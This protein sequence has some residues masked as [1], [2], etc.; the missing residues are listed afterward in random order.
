MQGV[1]GLFVLAVIAVLIAYWVLPPF[2][3]WGVQ[4]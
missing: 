4:Q 1:V 2:G 3:S